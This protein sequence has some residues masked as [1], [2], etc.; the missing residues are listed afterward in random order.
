MP[1]PGGA[2]DK[3]G[4]RYEGLWTVACLIKVIDETADS[5]RLE[6]PGEEG[7]GVEFWLGTRDSR[8]YY[9]VKRQNSASGCW[10][11][12]TLGKKKI[13]LSFFQKLR[14]STATCVFA[15]T[16]AAYQ[17]D[18]LAD[19][20]RRAAS[21]EEFNQEF[22]KADQK[23]VNSSAI[24]VTYALTGNTVLSRTL[25]KPSRGFVLKQLAKISFAVQMKAV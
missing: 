21:W 1:L 20:A 2:A 19:R 5:I 25:M 18:E 22:L 16:Q 8:T 11:L 3:F 10:T 12:S 7:E 17:L 4:N 24:S 14:D 9:Q 15:S 23:K 13:L 6:P